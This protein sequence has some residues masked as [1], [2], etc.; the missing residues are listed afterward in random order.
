VLVGDDRQCLFDRVDGGDVA[1]GAVEHPVGALVVVV[2]DLHDLVADPEDPAAHASFGRPR[3]GRGERLLQQ[4]VEVARACRAAVHGGEYLDVAARVQAEAPRDAAGDDVHGQF[5]GGL[6]VLA[7]EEEEVGHA[8]Q[9]DGASGVDAV[10]VGDHT[11]LGGLAEHLGEADAGYGRVLRQQ[12]AQDLSGA[13][14]RQ[15]VDV[16]D[17]EQVRAGWDG[18]GQ[19]VG[20][21]QVEHGCL[22]DDEQVAVEGVGAVVGGG[23]AGFELQQ[24]VHGGRL[25]SGE[26]GEAFGGASGG[27]GQD[28]PGAFGGGQGDD[29]RHGEGLAAAGS[30]GEDRDLAGQREFDRFFLFGG[31]FGAGAAVQPGQCPLP[32]HVGEGGQPVLFGVEQCAQWGGQRGLGAVEGDQVDAPHGVAVAGGQLLAYHPFVGDEFGQAVDDQ[33]RVRLE[34]LDR[35]VDERLL[36]Q[37]AVAVAGGFRQ[38]ELD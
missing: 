5:G 24:P 26:F 16:A 15:L 38:G 30:A 6:G 11:G 10:R 9:V 22:V 36:R 19:F 17:E 35:L 34:D 8:V 21:Q 25:V 29:G 7:G 4:R 20:E 3:A 1:E 13:H 37:V 14:R 2:A 18:L 23:A 27:G 12:V 31:Q 33:G 28:D 32:V